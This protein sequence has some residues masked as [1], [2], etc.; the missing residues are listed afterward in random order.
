[1]TQEK[2]NL[3]WNKILK[4]K[5]DKKMVYLTVF[6]LLILLITA[7]EK[8][9][10]GTLRPNLYFGTKSYDINS[11]TFGLMWYNPVTAHFATNHIRHDCDERHNMKRYGYT[12][13]NGDDYA[14]QEILDKELGLNL[15]TQFIRLS[16]DKWVTRVTGTKY[17]EPT[18][19][20]EKPLNTL[21]TN[22]IAFSYYVNLFHDNE[23]RDKTS[24][25]DYHIENYANGD[26]IRIKRKNSITYRIVRG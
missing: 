6:L 15:T 1:M 14:H 25:E 13:H 21:L 18:L 17:K 5:K 12:K 19:E 7:Y 4:K 23:K 22:P 20:I 9:D 11:P 26:V 8:G 16:D 10:W 3:K 2:K 24:Q